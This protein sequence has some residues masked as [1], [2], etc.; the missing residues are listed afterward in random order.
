MNRRPA[1]SRQRFEQYKAE[2]ELRHARSKDGHGKSRDRSALVLVGSFLRMLRGHRGAIV[3]S[4]STSTVATL[5]AL[6]PPAATKFVVD[7]VLGGHALPTYVPGWVPR[8]SW[9]L[10]VTVCVAVSAISLLK[11]GIHIWGRWHATRVTK[12]MQMS[13]RKRVFAH[14][15]RLPLHRVQEMKSRPRRRRDSCP[16]RSCWYSYRS[17]RSRSRP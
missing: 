14:T 15:V 8:D 11:S 2:F 10:L 7:Y 16:R 4:L 13:V 1:S 12:L 17:G 9:W 3:L 6:I 5:L